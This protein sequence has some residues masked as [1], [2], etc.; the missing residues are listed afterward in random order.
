MTSG[1]TGVFQPLQAGDPS[2]VAGYRLVAR[3]G[4]GG[5]GRVYLSHTRGGRPVAIK[6][7]RPELADDPAF[8]RRF[9]REVESA[10]R[11]RG[12]YTAELVDAD[13]DGVPPWLATLYV[14]GP[15]LTAAVARRGPLPVSA[16]LWL[17]AGVAEALQAI[18][19]VGVVHRDLKPSNVLLAADGPRVI[20]FGISVTAGLSSHTATGSTVGTPHFMAPEQATA[21]EVSP[22]TDV[23][24]LAQTAAFAAL[25]EPLYGDGVAPV[26]LYRIV[27]EEPDLS[28][29]PEPLRPLFARCLASDPRERA[30]PAEVVQWCRGRLGADAAAGAG[31]A[32]WNE[33]TGPEATVPGPARTPVAPSTAAATLSLRPARRRAPGRRTALVT[34]V[35]VTAGALLWTGLTWFGG[36]RSGAGERAADTPTSTPAPTTSARSTASPSR[37]SPAAGDSPRA[38]Q[39]APNAALATG[40]AVLSPV[41]LYRTNSLSL[42]EPMLRTDRRG[43]IRLDCEDDVDCALHSGTSRFVQ[44]FNGK[45]AS[46]DVCRRLL[47]GATGSAYRTWSLTAADAGTQICVGND[48][49]DVASL[50]IQVKQTVLPEDAF[51]QL[52]M[53]VWRK[54]A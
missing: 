42:G 35:T 31:P 6:V 15:S 41:W 27:H 43:D 13:T 24:A 10:R 7:V 44:L 22:A 18:H 48:S 39:P 29:L 2:V 5:M 49:G 9:R 12:A 52:G 36:D 28:R 34:A 23:F 50:T 4:S 37:I 14:P 32:V 54:A 21:G 3:L 8:R 16:V 25:G 30:T 20:D 45:T 47:S 53:T 40:A 38:L 11:V 19:S 17:M 26:V 51:L 46:P 33:V 1:I